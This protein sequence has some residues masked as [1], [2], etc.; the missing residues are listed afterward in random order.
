M[1][2]ARYFLYV[3]GV[4]LTLVFILDACLTGLPVMERSHV[5]SPVIRIHSDRKWPERIVFDTNVPAIALAP[6]EIV[7]DPF[8]SPAKVADV[9]GKEREREAFALMP[10]SDAKRVQPSDPGRRELKPQRQRKSVKRHVTSRS[11]LVWRQPQFGWFGNT[12]W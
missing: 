8:A 2:L 5:N 6:T 11:V 10:P 4:L 1:P 9:S 12:I 3:G 7:E